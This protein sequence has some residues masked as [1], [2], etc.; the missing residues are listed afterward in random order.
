MQQREQL[1]AVSAGIGR[2]LLTASKTGSMWSKVTLRL[3]SPLYSIRAPGMKTSTSGGSVCPQLML[4]SV[5]LTGTLRG[6]PNHPLGKYRLN[7]VDSA[8]GC[9]EG[10]SVRGM[11]RSSWFF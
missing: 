5:V 6:V 10:C 4:P 3:H 11:I 9:V 2:W 1:V 7:Q 8:D